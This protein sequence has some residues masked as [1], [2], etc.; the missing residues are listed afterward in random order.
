MDATLATIAREPLSYSG[1]GGVRPASLIRETYAS[2]MGV[3]LALR[4]EYATSYLIMI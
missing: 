2:L 1:S 4:I 3:I